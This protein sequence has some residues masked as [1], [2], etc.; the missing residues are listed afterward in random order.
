MVPRKNVTIYVDKIK[1]ARR[2]VGNGEL[3]YEGRNVKSNTVVELDVG[4]VNTRACVEP[5]VGQCEGGK[6]KTKTCVEPNVGQ[7][8]GGEFKTKICVEP[9]VGQFEGGEFK[10]KT[11]IELNVGKDED[12]VSWVKPKDRKGNT[13]VNIT[14]PG[15]RKAQGKITQNCVEPGALNADTFAM[16]TKPDKA[17]AKSVEPDGRKALRYANTKVIK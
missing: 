7:C 3:K 5:D 10:T 14:D 17:K 11:R 16:T 6:F 15:L 1:F 8:E 13:K 4:E 9:D 2:D 12:N